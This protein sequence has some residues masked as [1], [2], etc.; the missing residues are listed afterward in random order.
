MG[1]RSRT[2]TLRPAF[3]R[4][5]AAQRPLSPPPTTIASV[6]AMVTSVTAASIKGL[7]R[8]SGFL[9]LRLEERSL[10]HRRGC[11]VSLPLDGHFDLDARPGP[12]IRGGDGRD[13][14]IPLQQRRP[15]TARGPTDLTI[16]GVERHLLPPRFG[17]RLRWKTHVPIETLHGLPVDLE[18]DRTARG[19]APLFLQ[20]GL[21][22]DERTFVRC[23]RPVEAEFQR[24]VHLRI[25]N[26]FPRRHVLDLREDEPGL[27][28]CDVEGEH[29]RGRD[30][31]SL[32][33]LHERVPQ[34]L[35]PFALNPDFVSEV[36]RVSGPRDLDGNAIELRL[37]ESEVLQLLNSAI[38]RFQQNRPGRGSLERERS[39]VFGDV[40]H[41]GIQPHP[42]VLEP[43][44]IR[45]RGRHSEG[46]I[47]E[48]PKRAVVDRLAAFIAPWRVVDLSL[49]EFRRIPGDD[50]VHEVQGILPA[51][52][53][54]VERRDVEQARR[55]TDRVILHL[56]DEGVRRGREISG[57]SS[58]FPAV[59]QCRRPRMKW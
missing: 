34:R 6:D 26:R 2:S 46:P 39:D 1:R 16:A 50:V 22:P 44:Q 24:R 43:F 55:V 8:G 12:R 5:A 17:G 29:P 56:R 18:S 48:I 20:E 58:P 21:S 3:A 4:Y 19:T 49:R 41:L 35:G 7:P 47:P 40:V 31:V 36:A 37:D 10:D 25:D 45:L 33:P 27:D 59:A 15:A 51:D 30:V 57:P 13:C 32:T 9:S 54:L 53:V 28:P 14:D 42:R 38:S 23:E 11:P 52:E